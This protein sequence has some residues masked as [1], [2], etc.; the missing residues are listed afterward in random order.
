MYWGRPPFQLTPDGLWIGGIPVWLSGKV[1]LPALQ[2]QP[3]P[4]CHPH[5]QL[6]SCLGELPD[7][8]VPIS[9]LMNMWGWPVADLRIPLSEMCLCPSNSVL[10]TLPVLVSGLTAPSPQFGSWPGPS[11]VPLRVPGTLR[12]VAAFTS[13]VFCHSSGLCTLLSSFLKSVVLFNLFFLF[14]SFWWEGQSCL[15]LILSCLETEVLGCFLKNNCKI[16]NLK[17]CYY[18]IYVKF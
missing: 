13:L 2:E 1:M 8:A 6:F 15:L 10:Q 16:H 14:G 9:T 5:R 17:L 18:S 11:C 4:H 12:A 3:L 7:M